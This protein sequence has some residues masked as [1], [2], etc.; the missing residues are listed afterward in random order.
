LRN[1][2]LSQIVFALVVKWFQLQSNENYNVYRK[3]LCLPW[4]VDTIKVCFI[5]FRAY[6]SSNAQTD[7]G[8]KSQLC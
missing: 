2:N 1:D 3:I 8:E 6:N 4:D 5:L 7:L